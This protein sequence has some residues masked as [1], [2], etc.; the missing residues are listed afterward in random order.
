VQILSIKGSM[1]LA[2]SPKYASPTS[3]YYFLSLGKYNPAA[4]Y[5]L[6]RLHK[7]GYNILLLILVSYKNTKSGAGNPHFRGIHR[8][9]YIIYV[10]SVYCFFCLVCYCDM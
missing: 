2:P 10:G 7:G 9:K 6:T 1:Q 8:Q 5:K 3:Y 4:V